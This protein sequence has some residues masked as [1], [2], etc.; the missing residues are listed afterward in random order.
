MLIKIF[1][2]ITLLGGISSEVRSAINSDTESKKAYTLTA[3]SNNFPVI[4]DSIILPLNTDSNIVNIPFG[5]TTSRSVANDITVI[6]PL[7]ILSYDNI[8]S[9]SQLLNGRVPGLAGGLNVRGLGDALIVIDGV[10]RSVNSVSVEEIEQI[11]VLKDVNASML[12]GVQGNNGVVLIKTKRGKPNKKTITALIET[13]FSDPISFPNYLGSAEYMELYNEARANDGLAPLYTSAVIEGTKNGTNTTRYPDVNYYTPEFLKNSKPSSRLRTE[14]SGGNEKAQYYLNLGWERSGSLMNKGGENLHNDRLNLRSNIDFDVNKFIKSNIDIAGLFTL[15]NTPSGNFFGDASTLRPNLFPGLIDTSLITNKTLLRTAHLVEGKYVVGGS[16]LYQTNPYGYLNLG[17]SNKSLGVE[18]Q[19]TN[20]LEFDLASIAKG[21]TLRTNLSFDFNNRYSESQ[22]NTYAV[23]QPTYNNQGDLSL[24]RIGADR[25]SGALA[26][27]GTNLNKQI[28]MSALLDYSR[29]F[30]VDHA[31]SASVIGYADRYNETAIFQSD[32]HSHLGTRLS[33][34]YANKYIADFSAAVVSS[35]KLSPTNRIGFS[36][37]LALGWIVSEEDFLKDNSVIN[38]LKLK[39]S[40]GIINTDMSLT[41]YYAYE[42][43]YSTGGGITWNDGTKSNT[44]TVLSNV[45]NNNLFFEKRK[46]FN[47]GI[48]ALLLKSLSLGINVFREMESGL[49][50]VPV[51]SYPAY[52]GGL[53]PYENF[54]ENKYSGIELGLSW[55]KALAQDFSL[56]IGLT[57]LF[58]NS[59]VVKR[60][61]YWSED[62]LYR[63]GRSTSSIYGLQA[64]GLFKDA[65]DIASHAKQEF[66][67]V[68]PGD[69]KYKD[70]NNDGVVNADDESMIGQSG[71]TFIGGLNIRL[72]YKNFTFFTLITGQ[73]GA[74]RSYTNSYSWIYGDR[75][76]S[77][78]VRNRWTP[79]TATTA[80]YPRLTSQSSSNNFRTSTFWLYNNSLVSINRIQLSYDL[81]SGFAS[82]LH[83]KNFALYVRAY[84]VANFSKHRDKMELNIGSEPQYRSYMIGLKASF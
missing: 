5:K 49:I 24:T 33:Y 37:S 81:P 73:T 66:G 43:I 38:F 82:K 45:G 41:R 29:V 48:E 22:T 57:A 72:K 65:Q 20:G 14:F 31:I 42:D 17:G 70:L 83:A 12:Y 64:I 61:E 34:T 11:T 10:P 51:N 8:T 59:E 19:F 79:A 78:V 69:I 7:E 15:S 21:L 52:L 3:G 47:V 63:T 74:D 68:K 32:K 60:D 56:N 27:G 36:P 53:I 16:S 35:P 13:G 44:T 62:Y 40:G 4:P 9:V 67:E 58:E 84:N 50:T 54:G 2:S 28:S 39:L 46:E 75:K 18:V 23:Y 30:R 55:T 1:I 26:V 71:S 77:D 80:T 6:N 25:F 76:Y